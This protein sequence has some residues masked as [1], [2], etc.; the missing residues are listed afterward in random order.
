M[1]SEHLMEYGG[2]PVFAFSEDTDSSSGL[3]P[4]RDV[5]WHLSWEWDSIRFEDV[6]D[7]FLDAVDTTQVNHLIIGY[8]GSCEDDV[9]PPEVLIDAVDRFPALKSLF[10]GYLHDPWQEF[11]YV[12][13]RN[14]DPLLRAFPALERL[15]VHGD[16]LELSPFRSETLR[17]LRFESDALPAE[18]VRAVGASDL[19]SLEH[20]AMWLGREAN[21]RTVTLD[22]LAPFMSG[23]RLPALRHLGLERSSFQDDIAAAV[24]VAPI[25]ARLESL[26][27]ALGR[28]TDRGAEALLSG[29]PL[30]H[31]RRLDLCDDPERDGFFTARYAQGWFLPRKGQVLASPKRLDPGADPH[32]DHFGSV[33]FVNHHGFSDAMTERLRVTLPNVEFSFNLYGAR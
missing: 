13:S 9:Y 10:L 19:P 22:D 15:D 18:A 4:A 23:E 29:Q 30:T 25:V 17:T 21:G 7:P 26:S 31:L 5:A 3:P 24:A 11:S 28:L 8:W 12:A 20:L 6:F 27:L 16:D 33:R 2:L 32:S 1:M 14:L